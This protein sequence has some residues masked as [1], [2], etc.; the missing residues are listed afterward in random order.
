MLMT[1]ARTERAGA[2]W[3]RDASR[4]VQVADRRGGRAAEARVAKGA[5]APRDTALKIMAGG[6]VVVLE[7]A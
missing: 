2:A 3:R 1:R 4:E 6:S 5:G 7:L